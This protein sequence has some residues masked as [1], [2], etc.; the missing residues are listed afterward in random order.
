MSYSNKVAIYPGTFDPLTF[1]HLDIIERSLKIIDKLIIGVAAET[2]KQIQFSLKDRVDTINL[3]LE[4]YFPQ[5]NARAVGFEGLLVDFARNERVNLI[6]RGLRAASDFEYEFQL[7][8][9]NTK[10]AS[11]IETLFLP[12]SEKTHFVSSSIVKQI[13]RL[14]GDLK[15]FVPKEVSQ[16]LKD[17]YGQYPK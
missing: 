3:V 13:A 8:W 10:L 12:A 7:A 1:G 2:P 9:M 11:E 6:I 17:Y 14:G 16:Q 4:K 15:E 5:E